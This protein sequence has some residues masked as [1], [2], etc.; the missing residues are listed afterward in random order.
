MND[1]LRYILYELENSLGLV[2]LA[3]ILAVA[4][5]AVIYLVFKKKHG[6]EKKFPW[7]KIVLSLI[8]A[9]YLL[10]VVYATLLRGH[11]T[12]IRAHNLHRYRAWREAWNKFSVQNWVIVLLNVALF[13][14]LGGLL[15]LLWKKC[16]KWY[17]TLPMG[18]SVSLAIELIQLAFCLGSS[19]VADLF[20]NTLGVVIGYFCIMAFLS[21]FNEKGHKAKPPS[22][23][24][25]TNGVSWTLTCEL[26]SGKETAP[27]YR[28]Q[29][30]SQ[31]QCDA[32]ANELAQNMD[33]AVGLAT[34]FQES[35]YY[36]MRNPPGYLTVNY[37]DSGYDFIIGSSNYELTWVETDRETIEE[38]L[39]NFPVDIPE[40]A[41]FRYEGEGWHSFTVH[42]YIEGGFMYDGTLRVQYASDGNVYYVEDYLYNYAYY[43]EVAILS[44]EEAYS[45]LKAGRFY[46]G[47]YFEKVQPIAISVTQCVLAYQNDAKGFF[48]PV[49]I[50]GLE[51]PDGA[52]GSQVMIPAMK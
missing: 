10:I 16:R 30:R 11:S 17:V 40:A 6:K 31:A 9:G 43:G 14:P 33:M 7:G 42:Q 50:F 25:D 12:F 51:S 44:P 47:E 22:Y 18:F 32:F 20:T 24:K 35:A 49:Y 13:V 15:P 29:T 5:I 26:P 45:Q 23:T 38:A 48:H 52:I 46:D 3:L 8:L 4:V 2:M 41:E 36:N 21:L 39:A 37:Y 27:V 34:Y 19:D 1:Y 28:T